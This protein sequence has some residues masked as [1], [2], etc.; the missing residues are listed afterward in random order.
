MKAVVI[1][2]AISDFD[3]ARQALNDETI[4]RIAGSPGFVTGW[5]LAPR[6]DGK[7]MAVVIFDNEEA[8]RELLAVMQPGAQPNPHATIESAEL[9]DVAGHG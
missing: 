5:W 9:R 2:A 8:A 1:H 6:D 4:P 7:G 3:Q